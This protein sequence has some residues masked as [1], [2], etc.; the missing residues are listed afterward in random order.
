MG[1]NIE[2]AKAMP[3]T[4][5]RNPIRWA[6]AN[7]YG[8]DVTK[9]NYSVLL[10]LATA[11]ILCGG[12]LVAISI[13]I[14]MISLWDLKKGFYFTL[15]YETPYS[16]SVGV[17]IAYSIFVF[18]YQTAV[19]TALLLLNLVYL[20]SKTRRQFII[21]IFGSV[22]LYFTLGLLA[23]PGKYLTHKVYSVAVVLGWYV[24]LGVNGF[25][26]L[27]RHR[28]PRYIVPI[29]FLP[30]PNLLIL[31]IVYLRAYSHGYWFWF[32]VFQHSL[33]I[34]FFAEFLAFMWYFSVY[35]HY[36]LSVST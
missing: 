18:G 25:I 26:L 6:M 30:I 4:P 20:K 17:R 13:I 5:E 35:K 8:K 31:A 36:P 11:L 7:M 23:V 22:T 15:L 33:G 28:S 19:A 12:G 1:D 32:S 27:P 3:N 10:V 34:L 24:Y 16:G 9:R 2:E 21:W 14:S 29:W